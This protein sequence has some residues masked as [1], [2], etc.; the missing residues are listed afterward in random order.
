VV[1]ILDSG[2]AECSWFLLVRLFRL[3]FAIWQSL[4][5]DVLTVSGLSLFLL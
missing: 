3:P 5:L 4:V 1:D 2:V